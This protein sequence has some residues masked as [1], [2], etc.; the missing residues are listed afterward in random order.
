MPFSLLSVLSYKSSDPNNLITSE[1]TE[2]KIY[3]LQVSK[4]TKSSDWNIEN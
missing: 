1:S 3:R 4:L 2:N